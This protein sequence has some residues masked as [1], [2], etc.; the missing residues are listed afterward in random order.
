MLKKL[1]QLG[2][3]FVPL[4]AACVLP[5]HLQAQDAPATS[6]RQV[7][8]TA[9]SAATPDEQKD[10]ILAMRSTPS[11]EIVEWVRHRGSR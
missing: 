7:I 10:L 2:P 5:G 4:I 11:A 3:A 1:L 6:P 8:A 9:V